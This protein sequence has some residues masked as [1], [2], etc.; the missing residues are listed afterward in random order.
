MTLTAMFMSMYWTVT[1]ARF[2]S[3]DVECS[4]TNSTSNRELDKCLGVRPKLSNP[5]ISF[6]R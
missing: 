6:M 4:I 2:E 1:K 3:G 5:E